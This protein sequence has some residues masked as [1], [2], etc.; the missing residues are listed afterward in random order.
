MASV[1]S[2]SELGSRPVVGS[3]YR[4]MCG[5]PEASARAMATRRCMPIDSSSGMASTRSGSRP[6]S[7]SFSRAMASTASSL[8]FEFSN[9]Q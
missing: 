1:T 6:T 9:S 3:S 8:A 5:W 4:M 7:D 2:S